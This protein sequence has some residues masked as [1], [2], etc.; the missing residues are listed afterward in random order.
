MN[1][2]AFNELRTEHERTQ[3]DLTALQQKYDL[4][5]DLLTAKP[6][7]NEAFEQFK[8]VF[9]EDFM[10]FANKESSLADEATAVQRLQAL[11]KRLEQIVAFPHMFAKRSVAIGGGFSSGK[12]AFVNS[13]IAQP[14]IKL[15]E[16]VQPVTAIPSYVMASEDVSIKGYARTGATVDIAPEL[17]EQLS[18]DSMRTFSFNLK[19]LMPS[20]AV[21]VP[22]QAGFEHIC[23]IDTPGYDAAGGDTDSDKETAIN[24]LKDRAALIWMIDV[25][26]GTIPRS[27]LSF[28]HAME[29]DGLPLYVVLNK[30]DG[31]PPSELEGILAEVRDELEEDELE[32]V[33]ISAYSSLKDERGREYPSD[34]LSLPDFFHRQNQPVENLGAELK[35]E[36]EGVFAMYEAAIAHDEQ[37][38]QVLTRSLNDINLDTNELGVDADSKAVEVLQEK[39]AKL[40]GE[41]RKDF[42]PIKEQ[43]RQVKEQML[44]AGERVLQSLVDNV[45]SAAELSK[46]WRPRARSSGRSQSTRRRQPVEE[47][48][49]RR[50]TGRAKDAKGRYALH[51]AAKRNNHEKAAALLGQ[52]ADP[53]VRD[54]DGYAP[55]HWAAEHDAHE[56]AEVLLSR[57]ADVN[58]KDK[59]GLTSLHWAAMQDAHETAKVLL[60]Q[61]ADPNAKDQEGYAPLHW[62][63]E[64]NAYETAKV[65]LD[66]RRRRAS[67]VA[68]SR[69]KQGR[70]P[71]HWAAMS[72]A[73]E[74]VEVLLAKGGYRDPKDK[75]GRTPLHYAAEQDAYETAKVLLAKRAY[76]DPKDNK[77]RTPLRCA[78]KNKAQKTAQLLRSISG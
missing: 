64:Q 16:G 54:Q 66:R 67:I 76:R 52:G 47:P 74:T 17:Y 60:G 6:S 61:G 77:G 28:L 41:Q 48:A 8:K 70:T 29:L 36:L 72:N 51:E 27:D 12:S 39:I 53:N 42:A 3:A 14:G 55:L 10:A 25:G 62:A 71:L 40:R 38:S 30:A 50:A 15:P 26:N 75:Q 33:G 18:H 34:D 65:L 56:T 58:A 2:Q 63:A 23:L 21:E 68:N 11:E 73:H 37:A 4:V 46:V 31:K 43:M 19:D 1:Q 35:A 13:F 57:G 69:D 49:Q 20:I 9:N 5:S 32:P 22:L 24:S 44:Q 78:I 59:R 45:E 7:A